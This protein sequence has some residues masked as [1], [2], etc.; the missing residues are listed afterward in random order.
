MVCARADRADDLL[1]LRRRE[2]ELHVLRR[3]FYY[4]K[5]GV[6]ALGRHHVRLVEDEDLVA[7]PRRG[8][9]RPLAQIP[10]VVDTVVTRGIDLHD[11]H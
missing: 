6:E 3:F 7:I 1:R 5:E 4:F 11:I 2:N 10:R 9:H 8:E